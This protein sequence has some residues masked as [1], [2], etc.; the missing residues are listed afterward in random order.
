MG[1]H[2]KDTQANSKRKVRNE[3][4]MVPEKRIKKMG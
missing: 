3:K 1:K 4:E 2:T